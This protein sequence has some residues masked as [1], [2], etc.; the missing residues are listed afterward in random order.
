MANMPEARDVPTE[1][2]SR[3]ERQKAIQA[4]TK[5]KAVGPSVENLKLGSPASHLREQSSR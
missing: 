3:L 1:A 5:V 4:G 2:N